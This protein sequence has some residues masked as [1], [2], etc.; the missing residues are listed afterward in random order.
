MV[1]EKQGKPWDTRLAPL[2][3]V[4]PLPTHG[5]WLCYCLGLLGLN[6]C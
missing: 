3:L 6:L 5:Q 2:P 4:F 1:N